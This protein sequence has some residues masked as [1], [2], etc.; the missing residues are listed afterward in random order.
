VE[1]SPSTASIRSNSRTYTVHSEELVNS[2][3]FRVTK[4]KYQTVVRLQT[5]A[6]YS[7]ATAIKG[8]NSKFITDFQMLAGIQVVGGFNRI[9]VARCYYRNFSLIRLDF[10]L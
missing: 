6:H 8:R 4:Y 3:R 1:V 10:E 7:T 9:A 5:A 2:N